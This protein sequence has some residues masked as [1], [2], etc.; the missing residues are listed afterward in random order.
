MKIKTKNKF[1]RKIIALIVIIVCFVNAESV[2]A[3]QNSIQF[4]NITIDDGLAQGTVEVLFQDSNGYI[5]IGTNDG[6]NRY[7]GYNFKTYKYSEDGQTSIANN[8][9]LSIK[10]DKDKNIWVATINGL[11]KISSKDDSITN[12]FDS[13]E[14]GNLSN[15]N[16][17]DILITKDNQILVGT[18]DG[19]NLYNED[20]D[21]FE[22]ILGNEGDITSQDIYSL[23]EDEFGNIWVGTYYGLNKINLKTNKV[24]KFLNKENL[25][26]IS[27]NTIYKVYCDEDGYVW[28]GTFNSGVNKINI[29]TNEIT[30]YYNIE[31]NPD[32][33]PGNYVRN[34]L[35]DSQGN[36]W[37][38]T[39]NGLAKFNEEEDTFTNY[40]KDLGNRYSLLNNAVYSIIQDKT[41]LIWVGT[42]EGISIFNPNNNIEHYKNN[43]N[44][45]NSLSGNAVHG[46]YEDKN[47]LLW[48]GTNT[49]GLNIL[50]RQT[51]EVTRIS[52]KDGLTND[53]INCIVGDG[54]Y[55]WVG[56]NDGINK[57][58]INTKE[59]KQYKTSDG[60]LDIKVKKLLIDSKNNLW[61]GTPSGLNIL[62]I[63]K[64]EVI[65]IT[66]ILSYN[67]GST[68]TYVNTIYEDKEGNIWIGRIID[69]GLSKID[70]HNSSIVHYRKQTNSKDS[71]SSNSVKTIT[72]DS[73]GNLWIG[74][75]YGLNK[76]DKKTS[77]FTRYTEKDGLPNNT[78][79]GILED[80]EKNIWV[81]TNNGIGKLDVNKNVFFNYNITDGLQSNEF[82]GGAEFKN[83]KGEFFFGGL[84]GLN[85]FNPSNMGKSLDINQKVVFEEFNV[86]KKTYND[87]NDMKFKYSDNSIGIKFFYPNF[88]D[89]KNTRYYYKIEGL[90]EEWNVTYN[91]EIIYKNLMYGKYI[92]KIKAMNNNGIM[93]EE[94]SVSFTINPPIL[95]SGWAFLFYALVI[96]LII[97]HNACKMKKLDR[98]VNDRTIQLREEMDKSRELFN[99]VIELERS[100]NNYF[101]NLSHELRTPLNVIST[102]QQLMLELIKR[103]EKIEND[104]LKYH[105]KVMQKNT[106]RLLNL[107]NNIIDTSKIEHGNYEINIKENDIVY[108]VEEAALGLKDYVE[109]K[110]IQ[111]IIDPD[112]EEKIIECDAYEI[113]RCMVN[114]IS[115]AKKFTPEGGTIEVSVEDLNNKVLIRVKDNGIG[116][117]KKYQANIFDRFTQVIDK[118]SEQKGGSGLGLTITRNIVEMHNGKIYLESE[119]NKG[120]TFTIVLPVKV[121]K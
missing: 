113:E 73:N 95:L 37:I 100:K 70:I 40:Y 42:Y 65:D 71:I 38:C 108:I 44:D 32:S 19:L 28:V 57:I 97:K 51:D 89:S 33:L 94:N 104:R 66:S 92:F 20:K 12:Y 86:E 85:I 21:S 60:I 93:S 121:N 15:Y 18:A 49:K 41:G 31:N 63:A 116:I 3:Y 61:I 43:P 117:P 91:N 45:D 119:E 72:E 114:L 74:T 24:E 87:I 27:E 23:D 11:S 82:N 110:N 112:I 1:A 84:N 120:S 56:T 103:N 101:I 59:I 34:M 29:R 17:A 106:Q 46:I 8:Y 90:D 62:D 4:S 58:N 36:V 14:E 7:D 16:T 80:D 22:R 102:T 48:V 118:T 107:I 105:T 25:N 68:D 67:N 115:N 9:I 35:R 50:N 99:K 77:K 98:L 10:E 39:D 88:K 78:I 54:D 111:L 83:S 13:E 30:R 47:G 55:V 96:S 53:T 76:L 109:S 52:K 5:W 79:Y 69:G 75:D 26:S 81:S 64:D 6:L 2:H